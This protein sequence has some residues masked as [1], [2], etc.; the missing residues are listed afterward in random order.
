MKT[1]TFLE[2]KKKYLSLLSKH[3]NKKAHTLRLQM[4]NAILERKAEKKSV[5]KFNFH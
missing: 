1:K 3:K 5:K 2:T 4:F